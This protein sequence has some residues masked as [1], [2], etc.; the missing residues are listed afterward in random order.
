MAAS[1]EA[2]APFM[3]H[4]LV[5]YTASLPFKIKM[6]NT[7]KSIIKSIIKKHLPDYVTNAQKLVGQLLRP[8]LI[9]FAK[10]HKKKS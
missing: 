8:F 9:N 4:D 1:I 7:P 2:R 3:D 5:E 10:W 6:N